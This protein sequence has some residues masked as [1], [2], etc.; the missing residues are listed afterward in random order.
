MYSLASASKILRYSRGVSSHTSKRF[1]SQQQKIEKK[2]KN[3]DKD[4]DKGRDTRN[5]INDNP[6]YPTAPV[7]SKHKII[8]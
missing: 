5:D 1:V 3:K 8:N 2:E 4:K 7:V 6:P